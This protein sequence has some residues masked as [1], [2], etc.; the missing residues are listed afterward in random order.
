MQLAIS[1]QFM[2]FLISNVS[3]IHV[4]L[5][6]GRLW[7][8]DPCL[9]FNFLFSITLSSTYHVICSSS[10]MSTFQVQRHHLLYNFAVCLFNDTSSFFLFCIKR[11]RGHQKSCQTFQLFVL[12]TFVIDY[13]MNLSVWIKGNLENNKVVRWGSSCFV[14]NSQ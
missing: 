13:M 12:N 11:Q 2:E 5:S 9:V 7:L 3:S 4:F 14:K 1:N 10:T 6:V 8:T